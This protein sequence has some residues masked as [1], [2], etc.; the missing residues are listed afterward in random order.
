MDKDAKNLT[1]TL[2]QT[3]PR[4]RERANA[5]EEAAKFLMETHGR[6]DLFGYHFSQLQQ[7]TIFSK[8]LESMLRY[9]RW[10]TEH[11]ESL[12][13]ED[14]EEDKQVLEQQ[15]Q[16]DLGYQPL[17]PHYSKQLSKT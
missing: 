11:D 5:R 9:W 13:G 14:Y 15:A 7:V 2:L 6:I 12:R 3:N 16:I 8:K 1:L 4:F 10:W 17:H